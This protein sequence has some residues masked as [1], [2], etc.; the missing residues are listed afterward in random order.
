MH[1]PGRRWVGNRLA[2]FPA[3]GQ[4]LAG[5]FWP[6]PLTLVLPKTGLVSDLVTAGAPTVA[7]RIP[8]HPLALALLRAADLPMFGNHLNERQAYKAMF[9]RRLSLAE[10][11]PKQV[12]GLAEAMGNAQRL[13]EELAD[14]LMTETA[15]V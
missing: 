10:L 15:N 9:A 14:V 6:G 12:S 7:V 3:A 4:R 5:R 2:D 11:N 13:A 8:D 1:S